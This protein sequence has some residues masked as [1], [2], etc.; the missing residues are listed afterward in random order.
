MQTSRIRW[1]SLRHSARSTLPVMVRR[2]GQTALWQH[3]R[4]PGP[5]PWRTVM[6]DAPPLP[7]YPAF[8]KA[9]RATDA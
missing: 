3:R 9:P 7:I 5:I 2:P 4:G 8:G 1:E 6:S